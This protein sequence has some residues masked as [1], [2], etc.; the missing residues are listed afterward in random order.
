MLFLATYMI[1]LN[2]IKEKISHLLFIFTNFT[3]LFKIRVIKRCVIY[4]KKIQRDKRSVSI[5]IKEWSI[6]ISFT[7]GLKIFSPR[8]REIARIPCRKVDSARIVQR[9]LPANVLAYECHLRPTRY[10]IFS[11]VPPFDRIEI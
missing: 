8:R 3:T 6:N 10:M 5:K 2:I 9:G 11:S 4:I 7:K 1:Y